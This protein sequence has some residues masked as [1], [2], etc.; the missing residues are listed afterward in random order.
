MS[1]VPHFVYTARPATRVRLRGLFETGPLK[2]LLEKPQI[3]RDN[4][5]SM[6]TQQEARIV[7]GEYL[8]IVLGDWKTIQLYEDGTIASHSDPRGRRCQRGTTLSSEN[9]HAA[10]RGRFVSVA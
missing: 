5:W 7:K 9:S 8:E 2:E 3:L 6:E 1:R 10:V 4:G